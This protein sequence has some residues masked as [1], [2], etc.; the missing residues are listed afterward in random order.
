MRHARA[1][2]FSPPFAQAPPRNCSH[3][4]LTALRFAYNLVLHK[5]GKMLYD[6]VRAVIRQHLDEAVLPDVRDAPSERI[7]YILQEK[8]ETFQATSRM[9][10]DILMYLV[11]CA[12]DER[13]S[14]RYPVLTSCRGIDRIETLPL[15][16]SCGP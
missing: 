7:L 8:W 6:G 4:W 10:A 15:S 3:A 9:I 14:T 16:K 13:P 1:R 2:A 12:N 5:H 11:R